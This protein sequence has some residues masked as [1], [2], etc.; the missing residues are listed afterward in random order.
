MK[1]PV[2]CIREPI[3]VE[4]RQLL[5]IRVGKELVESQTILD[6][7]ILVFPNSY[8]EE[9]N[10]LGDHNF[11]RQSNFKNVSTGSRCEIVDS[12]L[13]DVI[14]GEE[15]KIIKS[16]ISAGQIGNFVKIEEANIKDCEIKNR[17]FIGPRAVLKRALVDEEVKIPHHCYLADCLIGQHSNIAAGVITCNFD[18]IQKHQTTIEEKCFIGAGVH[19]IAPCVIGKESFIAERVSIKPNEI[20]PAHSFVVGSG[21]NYE[22][23]LFRSFYLDNHLWIVTKNPTDPLLIKGIVEDLRFYEKIVKSRNPQINFTWL[24]WLLI[25]NEKI[26]SHRPVELFK[27][28]ADYQGLKG[29]IALKALINDETKNQSP[30]N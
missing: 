18:G 5:K 12:D 4:V 11:V 23:N 9:T 20:I 17:V 30:I 3:Y 6:K 24:Q 15:T 7:D 28:A 22:V 16:R 21:K 14:I 27:N 25:P 19:L 2:A 26:G 13:N 29:A 1:M 8:F 10:S